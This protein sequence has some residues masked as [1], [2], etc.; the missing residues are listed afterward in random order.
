MES[1]D[2]MPEEFTRLR[3][4]SDSVGN[5]SFFITPLPKP[6]FSKYYSTTYKQ[7]FWDAFLLM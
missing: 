5:S 2:T 1:L 3:F 4:T 7:Q 6:I